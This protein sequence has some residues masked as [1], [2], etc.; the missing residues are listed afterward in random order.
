M[1]LNQHDADC[2]VN[3]RIGSLESMEAAILTLEKVN[4]RIGSL[5]SQLGFTIITKV[6]NCR[7]GSLENLPK[8]L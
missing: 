3:C 8:S 7:I 5:E 2:A 4:C 1:S 6:V